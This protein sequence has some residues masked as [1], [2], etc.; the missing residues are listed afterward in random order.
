MSNCPL[1]FTNCLPDQKWHI[2]VLQKVKVW[3]Q[4]LLEGVKTTH[5]SF[6][7]C[8]SSNPLLLWHEKIRDDMIVIKSPP[9]PPPPP[10]PQRLV[11]IIIV[12]IMWS[13]NEIL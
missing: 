11:P 13:G 1:M 9:P 3:A 8:E 12:I 5:L 4:N 7:P 2:L 10:P 6:V